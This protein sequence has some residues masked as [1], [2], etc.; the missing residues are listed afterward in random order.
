MRLYK[1]QKS[2]GSLFF[3]SGKLWSFLRWWSRALPF[4]SFFYVSNIFLTVILGQLQVPGEISSSTEGSGRPLSAGNNFEM[5]PLLTSQP[6]MKDS[7]IT[8]D[9]VSSRLSSLSYNNFRPR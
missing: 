1:R 2:E 4:I 3:L 6:D 5:S 8:L 7:I 9:Y